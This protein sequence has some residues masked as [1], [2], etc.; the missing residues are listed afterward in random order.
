MACLRSFGVCKGLLGQ[1]QPQ[2]TTREPCGRSF[3]VVPMSEPARPGPEALSRGRNE[4]IMSA[5][6]FQVV[7]QCQVAGRMVALL[8][9]ARTQQAHPPRQGPRTR[10]SALPARHRVRL[11]GCARLDSWPTR[12]T[13]GNHS[14]Q[15]KLF[16]RPRE[17][18]FMALFG[19]F[20][21]ACNSPRG[22]RQR[23]GFMYVPI[24]HQAPCLIGR[25]YVARRGPHG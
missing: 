3:G 19:H 18:R 2:A 9:A 11:G 6:G 21:F 1:S 17:K 12:P 20:A 13:P 5:A 7:C 15:L 14:T 23:S 25:K 22:A 4:L 16:R 24:G 10:Q 8:K